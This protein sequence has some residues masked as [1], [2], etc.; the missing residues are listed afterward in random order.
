MQHPGDCGWAGW[1][2]GVGQKFY[3]VFVALPRRR[4]AKR[5]VVEIVIVVTVR[6]TKNHGW[7]ASCGTE[8]GIGPTNSEVDVGGRRIGV[9]KDSASCRSTTIAKVQVVLSTTNVD[10]GSSRVVVSVV[11]VAPMG[12]VHGH[13][14]LVLTHSSAAEVAVAAAMGHLGGRSK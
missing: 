5:R 2:R 12:M 14:N 3:Q 1:S 6:S 4:D 13:S 10:I 9:A 8:G 7:V 11:A